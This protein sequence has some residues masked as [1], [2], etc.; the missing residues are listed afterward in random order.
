MNSVL[1]YKVIE[2]IGRIYLYDPIKKVCIFLEN[3]GPL[4][5]K[6]RGV[7]F[8]PI[9]Q[10]NI[11]EK[12]DYVRKNFLYFGSTDLFLTLQTCTS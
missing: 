1:K 12:L 5:P 8:E 4:I 2:F 3:P 7:T 11:E 10:R 9:E 6:S